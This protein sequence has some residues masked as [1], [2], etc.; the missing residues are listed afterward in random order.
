MLGNPVLPTVGDYFPSVIHRLAC[1]GQVKRRRRL[2]FRFEKSCGADVQKGNFSASSKI[3]FADSHPIMNRISIIPQ[4]FKRSSGLLQDLNKRYGE[5][6]HTPYTLIKMVEK[7]FLMEI[8]LMYRLQQPRRGTA[9]K[10]YHDS[11]L[12]YLSN[13]GVKFRCEST[14]ECR[15]LIS[16]PVQEHHSVNMQ[17]QAVM[18]EE[19]SRIKTV[20]YRQFCSAR[21]HESLTGGGSYQTEGGDSIQYKV[22]GTDKKC[23]RHRHDLTLR[24][25]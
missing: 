10:E 12:E 3:G 4:N 14:L 19:T 6:E 22:D 8:W 20:S 18:N 7:S 21:P 25:L 23:C 17:I 1:Q 11:V 9:L 15:A 5:F 24:Y 2:V 13:L 16:G